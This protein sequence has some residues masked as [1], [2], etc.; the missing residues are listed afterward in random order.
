MML[1]GGGARG[2]DAVFKYC[3]APTP[4]TVVGYLSE[5]LSGGERAPLPDP[6]LFLTRVH[7][8]NQNMSENLY[9]LSGDGNLE[10][11]SP[12]INRAA[13][14]PRLTPVSSPWLWVHQI[15][16][17][18]T[19]SLPGEDWIVFI[20]TNPSFGIYTELAIATSDRLIVPVNADDSSRVATNAMFM[21]LHGTT[22]PHPVYGSWTFAERAKE[23]H[24]H[25]P[26][27]HLIV[28]NRLTSYDGVAGAFEALSNATADTLF[29]A[30]TTNP[31][32]FSP[33]PQKPSSVR[34]FRKFY[35]VPLRD[36]NTAGVMSAHLGMRMDQMKQ[37]IYQ[38]H[39]RDVQ[40]KEAQ[41]REARSAVSEVISALGSL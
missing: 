3:T 22:P 32:R 7:T 41:L 15:F 35:S 1:L 12:A 13:D 4:K 5:V 14:A 29:V 27:V 34:A 8:V 19:E 11:M 36:F 6:M 20:D 38:A 31:D 26:Q 23:N 28:G 33:R 37:G 2:E 18:L 16:R 30:Y 40:V 9:L 24:L 21:L 39:S 17:K 25:V 10:P